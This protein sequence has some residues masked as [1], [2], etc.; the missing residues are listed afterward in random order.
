M[1]PEED[2][3]LWRNRFILVN[4]VRIGATA[5]V[6]LALAIWYTDLLVPGGSMAIG[7]PLALAGVVVSFLGPKWLARRW[8]SPPPA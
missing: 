6:L 3:A 8:R 7:M 5:F 2:E 4:L 1:T